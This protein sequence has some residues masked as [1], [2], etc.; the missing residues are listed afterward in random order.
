MSHTTSHTPLTN[1]RDAVSGNLSAMIGRLGGLKRLDVLF[2]VFW[3][4]I[5]SILSCVIF[6]RCDG[7]PR[8]SGPRLLKYTP[9]DV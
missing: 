2:S 6:G 1:A 4:A 7:R 5:A 8:G 9:T 3:V